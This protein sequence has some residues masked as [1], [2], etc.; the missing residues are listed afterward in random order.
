M[1][2]LR[3]SLAMLPP[4]AMGLSREKAM[5]VHA[6]LQEMDQRVRELREGL[7]TLLAL[8]WDEPSP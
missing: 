2:S 8:A 5:R 7:L 4:Q 3:R 1:E 6:E